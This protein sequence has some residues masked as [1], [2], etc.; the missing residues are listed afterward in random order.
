MADRLAGELERHFQRSRFQADDD[1]VFCHPETGNVLDPSKLRKRF[2]TAVS[3]AKVHEI[4][5]HEPGAMAT[6]R[7]TALLL[8]RER[9]T[10]WPPD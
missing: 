8:S 6:V 1:Y 7:V 9:G 10:P 2:G 3:R 4:T 5:F